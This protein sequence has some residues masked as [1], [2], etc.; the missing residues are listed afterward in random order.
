M[1]E[2]N[3]LGMEMQSGS[4]LVAVERIAQDGRIQA[5][6][7]GTMH[8]QLV[9]SARL[10]IEGDAEMGVVDALQDFILR[11]GLLALFVIHHL[12]GAVQ[13][14]GQ[15]RKGNYSLFRNLLLRNLLSRKIFS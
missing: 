8:A 1:F 10:G 5:L 13:I 15:K 11:D 14:I 6:L 12:A 4:L 2:G 7:M 9:G 3:L